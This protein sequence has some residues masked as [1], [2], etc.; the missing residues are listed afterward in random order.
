MNGTLSPEG[1]TPADPA[2][3]CLPCDQ[4]PASPQ[5]GL[6]LGL[7]EGLRVQGDPSAEKRNLGTCFLGTRGPGA[8]K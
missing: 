7:W 8:L 3:L 4:Q 2:L 5:L 6:G 1:Q